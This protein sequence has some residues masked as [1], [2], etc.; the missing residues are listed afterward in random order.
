MVIEWT[1]TFSLLTANCWLL[2]VDCCLLTEHFYLNKI[3]ILIVLWSQ[4]PNGLTSFPIFSNSLF[5]LSGF[6][7]SFSLFPSYSLIFLFSFSNVDIYLKFYHFRLL[8][9]HIG[10][11]IFRYEAPDMGTCIYSST[12]I[13]CISTWASVAFSFKLKCK[14]L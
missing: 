6:A 3:L 12:Y 10:I 11:I 2:T 9:F 13:W 5:S 7:L 4:K 8:I 14:Y 1:I